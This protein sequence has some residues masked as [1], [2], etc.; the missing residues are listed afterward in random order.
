[1]GPNYKSPFMKLPAL[2][3]GGDAKSEVGAGQG[4]KT[5]LAEW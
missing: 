4:A 3:S 5:D 2:W 1:M